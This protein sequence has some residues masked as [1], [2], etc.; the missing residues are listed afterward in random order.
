MSEIASHISIKRGSERSFG[1]VFFIFF[2]II[3]LYPLLDGDGLRLWSLVVAFTFLM[4]GCLAPKALSIPNKLWFKLGTVLGAITAPILMA[5]VYFTAVLPVGLIMR[6]LGKSLMG[7]K[8]DK[9]AKSYWLM[10]DKPVGTMKNQ[11]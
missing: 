1:V 3:G 6:L 2:L 5:L 10:R 7:L 8:L 11:F 9:S 4:L